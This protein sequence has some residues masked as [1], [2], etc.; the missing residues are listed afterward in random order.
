ME[1][2]ARIH[3]MIDSM[4]G[5]VLTAEEFDLAVE[6]AVRNG[7]TPTPDNMYMA[8]LELVQAKLAHEFWMGWKNGTEVSLETDG[9]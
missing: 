2:S 7:G 9:P 1:L 8:I 4:R 3:G 6:Q 5:D